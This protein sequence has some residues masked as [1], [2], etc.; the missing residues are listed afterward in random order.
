MAAA[1]FAY[2]KEYDINLKLLAKMHLPAAITS[3]ALT[4]L[5][6][7]FLQQQPSFFGF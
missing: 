3:T 7:E 1:I 2:A 4:L 6:V 5:N